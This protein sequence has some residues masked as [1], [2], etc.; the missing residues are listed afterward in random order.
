MNA[1][2]PTAATGPLVSCQGSPELD[3]TANL[4]PTLLR[5]VLALFDVIGIHPQP[6]R[7][8]P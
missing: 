4:T 6:V 8:S 3:R 1:P 7:L 5:Q 2:R